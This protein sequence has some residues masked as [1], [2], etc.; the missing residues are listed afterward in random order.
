MANWTKPLEAK[1]ENLAMV[2]ETATFRA[3]NHIISIGALTL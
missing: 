3:L 2:R 1:V